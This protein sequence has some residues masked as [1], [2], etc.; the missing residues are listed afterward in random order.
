LKEL[1]ETFRADFFG[2]LDYTIFGAK[3]G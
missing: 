2:S 3:L 1:P